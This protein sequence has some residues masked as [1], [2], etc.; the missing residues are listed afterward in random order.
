VP[1]VL[2]TFLEAV[3]IDS[4]S[5][6]EAEFARWCERRLQ[7]VGCSVRF[8]DSA[9]RSGSD[10]GNLIAELPGTADGATVVLSAHLD[11]VMPGRGIRPVVEDGV[12]RSSG[13]T[14]LAADDKAG[15]AALLEALARVA[16]TGMVTAPVRVLLTTGEEMG[17]QGAKAISPADC[18]GDLCLV[19]DAHGAVGGIVGA[20]PTQYTFRAEFTGVPAH[21]GVEPEKGLSA[22]VMAANAISRMRLGRIDD[23]TTANVGEI[24]GGT[25]TNVVAASCV[26]RGECRSLDP[27]AAEAVRREM[28]EAMR[29]AASASGGSVRTEWTKEYEGFRFAPDDP[30]VA[31]VA[32]ACGDAGLS[33]QVFSTGGGSDANVLSA[34]GLPS[35]VLSCGMT[36]VH[37]TAESIAVTDLESLAGLLIAVL[38]RAV[39]R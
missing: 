29:G 14:I 39:R 25:A 20:S 7:A 28:D 17:L 37:S 22:I 24:G 34:K 4:P 26:M 10:S 23:A 2:E 3:G 38:A 5:G 31:L 33:P 21:A 16:E 35:I 12:V 1:R 8:D 6:E 13:D 27:Q 36:D 9:S 11:T 18:R 32:D 19:L 15:V 30:R